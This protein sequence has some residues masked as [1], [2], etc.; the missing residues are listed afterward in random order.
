M[1]DGTIDNDNEAEGSEHPRNDSGYDNTMYQCGWLR[2]LNSEPTDDMKVK[3]DET[4]VRRIKKKRQKA[5]VANPRRRPGSPSEDA[6]SQKL[7]L[8]DTVY[9]ALLQR[10][11]LEFYYVEPEDDNKNMT[12]RKRSSNSELPH[13]RLELKLYTPLLYPSDLLVEKMFD[14][15]YPILLKSVYSEG[16]S[17][18]LYL[19]DRSVKEDWFLALRKVCKTAYAPQKKSIGKADNDFSFMSNLLKKIHSDSPCKKL[20]V[21]KSSNVKDKPLPSLASVDYSTT[22]FNALCGRMFMSCKESIQFQEYFSGKIRKKL[23][24]LRR[25][26]IIGPIKLRSIEFGDAA[27]VIY[28][29]KL[30]RLTEDGETEINFDLV[31]DGGFKIEVET[32]AVIETSLTNFLIPL[33]LSLQVKELKG[34]AV[35]RIKP[36]PSD[37]IW[38]GFHAP[39][40]QLQMNINPV[41]WDTSFNFGVIRQTIE[42]RINEAVKEQLVLPNMADFLFPFIEGTV[43]PLDSEK[44]T[45]T[46]RGIGSILASITPNFIGRTSRPGSAETSPTKETGGLFKKL[47]KQNSAKESPPLKPKQ[48][49]EAPPA[50][51]NNRFKFLNIKRVKKGAPLPTLA[52]VSTPTEAFS[53]DVKLLPKLDDEMPMKARSKTTSSDTSSIDLQLTEDEKLAII[54]ALEDPSLLQNS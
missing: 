34:K 30:L 37:R 11:Y 29:A 2:V 25:P 45:L 52:P 31:Y 17:F 10:D 49:I 15:E 40:P 16:K 22:W 6:T 27:P 7:A 46:E 48:E 8:E 32:Y 38:F 51:A 5:K 20:P 14:N 53:P 24:S 12:I 9:F 54:N 35:V 44:P 26:Q 39:G 4:T 23:K 21:F 28:D 43:K 36:N 47:R 18:F 1:E 19:P 33:I 3:L 42:K 50:I 13:V 41:A